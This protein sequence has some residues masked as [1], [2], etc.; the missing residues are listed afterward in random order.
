MTTSTRRAIRV[1]MAASLLLACCHHK[2]P[3]VERETP[4]PDVHEGHAT[5]QSGATHFQTP[6]KDVQRQRPLLTHGPDLRG[7]P[8]VHVDLP[9]ERRQRREVVYIVQVR[10]YPGQTVATVN[11]SRAPL[12]QAAAAVV[13]RR[14]RNRPKH[15]TPRGREGKDHRNYQ[16]Y[17]VEP[18]VPSDR[19]VARH[20]RERLIGRRD[21]LPR[22]GD[23]F[24]LVGIEEPLIRASG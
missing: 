19:S 16:R 10:R 13:H 9:V 4:M 8:P 15:E 23:A 20:A 22:K 14:L 12:A 2:R 1:A 18:D 11:A 7:G 6:G 3:A 21:Q 24:R 5:P 17:D